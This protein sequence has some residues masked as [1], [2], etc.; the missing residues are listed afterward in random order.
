MIFLFLIFKQNLKSIVM[1]LISSVLGTFDIKKV[2]ESKY[3]FS[4]VAVI[5]SR[6]TFSTVIQKSQ[7]LVSE[8]SLDLF[9]I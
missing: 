1:L 6:N 5:L 9:V 7:Q 8:T 3:F 4:W 2:L